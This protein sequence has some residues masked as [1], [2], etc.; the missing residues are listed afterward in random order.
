MLC[1]PI[2][3]PLE[4]A[5]ETVS[6]FILRFV[7]QYPVAGLGQGDGGCE[8]RRPRAADLDEISLHYVAHFMLPSLPASYL[9]PPQHEWSAGAAPLAYFFGSATNFLWQVSE[10]K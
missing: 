6:H 4:I 1:A 9:C 3:Q 2:F 5:V 7:N 10:Q 8:P